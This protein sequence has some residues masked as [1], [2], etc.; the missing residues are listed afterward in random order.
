M[1]HLVSICCLAVAL[2]FAVEARAARDLPSIAY[3]IMR[4]DL[5][6]RQ[7][8]EYVK[9][10]NDRYREWSDENGDRD[11]KIFLDD[12]LLQLG[13][14][15]RSGKIENLKK[16]VYFL[17]LYK[18]WKELAPKY[19]RDVAEKNR[20]DLDDLLAE[21]TWERASQLVKKKVKEHDETKR[22][23]KK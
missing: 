9:K 3:D 22:K 2:G 1:N 20:Q 18:Q 5:N 13:L 21:F 6:E 23:E 15:A 11:L 16:F 10:S 12:R 4:K 17:S 7:W 8:A 19:I 14:A